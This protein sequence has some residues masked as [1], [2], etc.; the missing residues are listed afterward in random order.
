[1]NNSSKSKLFLMEF[2][3]V[4]LMFAVSAAACVSAFAKADYISRQGSTLSEATLI[5][6]TVAEKI[7]SA[8]GEGL[9]RTVKDIEAET[10]STYKD[11]YEVQIRT[12]KSGDMFTGDIK[13][14]NAKHEEIVYDR[15]FVCRI[16]VK[17]YLPRL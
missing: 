17:R 16:E 2:I 6:A 5:A 12:E 8:K 1:M 4:V 11:K 13:V 14:F 15:D 7:K 10:N 3:C 9:D